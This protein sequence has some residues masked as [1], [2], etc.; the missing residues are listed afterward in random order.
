MTSFLSESYDKPKLVEA[1]LVKKIINDQNNKITF[2][3]KV[4][5]TLIDFTKKNYKIIFGFLLIG[6]LLFWRYNDIKKKRRTENNY[7]SDSE[8]IT[9][10]E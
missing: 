7:E 6:S 2:E 5:T 10:E 1:K 3:S 9:T 4:K 8:V